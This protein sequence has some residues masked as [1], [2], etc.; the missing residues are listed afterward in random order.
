ME[1]TGASVKAY[2]VC[3]FIC[4]LSLFERPKSHDPAHAS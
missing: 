2:E 1:F 3:S 4:P